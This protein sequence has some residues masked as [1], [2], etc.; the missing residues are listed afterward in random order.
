QRDYKRTSC[1]CIFR[2]RFRPG[3]TIGLRWFERTACPCRRPEPARQKMT[4]AAASGRRRCNS[5]YSALSRIHDL[6]WTSFLIV[7]FQ[8]VTTKTGRTSQTVG[9]SEAAKSRLKEKGTD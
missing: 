3:R 2:Q 9:Y 8:H 1:L 5:S 4:R 7:V 6:D